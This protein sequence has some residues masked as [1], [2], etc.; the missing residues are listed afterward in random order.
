MA[1]DKSRIPL[2][3]LALPMFIE[4]IIRTSLLVVDQLMLNRFSEKAAAA[5][6]SV[7]QLAFFIQMVFLMVAAGM[8]ILVSQMLGAGKKEDASRAATA[9]MVIMA[10]FAVVV[11]AAVVLLARPVLGIYELEDEVRA[12][13][14]RF[15]TIY[16][17]GSFF[18]AMNLAQANILRAYGHA[19]DPMTINAAA[20]GLTIIGNAVSLYGPFGLPVTGMTGV[21][22]SNVIGQAAAFFLS[23]WRI[24]A[25]KE[26]SLRWRGLGDIPGRVYALI[27]KV[28]VPTA[29]E[30][31]SYNVAAIVIV[32]FISRMG[33][34]ALAAYGIAISLSRYVFITGV[35]IGNAAQIKVGYYVGAGRPD[36]A[37]RRVWRWF[38]TGFCISVSVILVLNLAKYPILSLFTPN[39]A[40]IAIAASA[41]TVGFALEPARNFNTIIIPA[42]KGSGDTLFPVLVGMCFQWGFGV[43]LAW[44]F[45]LKLG[46]GLAGVWMGMTCDEWSRGIAMALR[47]RSGAWRKKALI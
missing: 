18:M 34:D 16:G 37:Y 31:V 20:L 39:A 42:L 27:L 14:L 35:S 13:A 38:A 12:M 21:A 2:I 36:E 32:G 10:V 7:N 33:T 44:L 26:I 22:V 11:G 1:E 43:F 28:G 30:N 3:V 23:S 46:L 45:G 5:M 17:A 9:G 24:R 6:S 29:G 40:I 4:N 25:R 8:S 15:L 41:L 19:Y 47:W